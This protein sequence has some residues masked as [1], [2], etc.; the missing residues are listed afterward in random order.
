MEE[1]K[2]CGYFMQDGSTT[3][4]VKYSINVS[5]EIDKNR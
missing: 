5:F 1:E 3:H 2:A 4:S